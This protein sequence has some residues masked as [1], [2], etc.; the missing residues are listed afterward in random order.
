M[1]P[2]SPSS[3]RPLWHCVADGAATGAR[4][5]HRSRHRQHGRVRAWARDRALRAV[6][7][8]DRRAH[9]RGGRRRGRCPADDR[10]HSGADLGDPPASPRGDRRLRGDRADASPLH[11]QGARAPPGAATAGG[12]CADRDHRGGASRGRGGRPVCG[13]APG[14]PH[15]GADRRRHRRRG[16]DRRA[17][18]ADGH[19]RR[20]GNERGGGDLDGRDGPVALGARRRIRPRRGDRDVHPLRPPDG[21]RLAE[22][23]GAQARGGLGGAAGRRA[24]HLRPRARCGLRAASRDRALERPDPRRPREPAQRHPRRG[25]GHA[26]GDPA[27]AGE[28]HLTRRHPAGGRRRPAP[29]L[30]RARRGR[31]RDARSTGRFPAHLRRRRSRR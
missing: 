23:R 25:A 21:D 18:R 7:G 19:R 11:A 24:R 9:R 13:R 27:R 22:R 1:V 8:G 20:R 30:R 28:R 6:R 4:H 26:G 3:R 14:A 2:G 16:R 15:R 10:P 12:L 31:D 29:R 5:G 17:D